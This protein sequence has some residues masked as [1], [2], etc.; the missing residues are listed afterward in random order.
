MTVDSLSNIIRLVITNFYQ[1]TD[2]QKV[3]FMMFERGPRAFVGTTVQMLQGFVHRKSY[4]RHISQMATTSIYDNIT[5]LDT[6]QNCLACFLAQV[7]S[8]TLFY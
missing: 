8:K 7:S 5:A 4:M 3:Y 6:V 2:A 1:G